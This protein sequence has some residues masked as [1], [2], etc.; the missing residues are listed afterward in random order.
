MSVE[1]APRLNRRL[2]RRRNLTDP[3][4]DGSVGTPPDTNPF[5]EI[6]RLQATAGNRAVSRMLDGSDQ[7]SA[8]QFVPV[9]RLM[10][11]RQFLAASGG[12]LK[13]K[14]VIS[15]D[16]A[17]S[18]Y[19]K[20]DDQDFNARKQAAAALV[21]ACATYLST[22]YRSKARK[23]GVRSLLA[24]A[25]A[26][27]DLY[28]RLAATEGL[29][30]SARMSAL[31][32]LSDV[33]AGY[34]MRLGDET[35]ATLAIQGSLKTLIQKHDQADPSVLAKV[36]ERE[37][38]HLQDIA[39]DRK[40]PPVVRQIVAEN[41][42][43]IDKIHLRASEAPGGASPGARLPK[44]GEDT[45]G[46]AYVVNHALYQAGGSAE[47][48]GSLLHELTHVASGEEIGHAPLFVVFQ[49]GKQ[50]TPEGRRELKQLAFARKANVDKM[51]AL[52]EGSSS[53]QPGQRK[54]LAGKLS[55]AANPMLGEYV[56][57]F[58]QQLG[59]DASAEYKSMK[60]LAED[61]EIIGISST[62]IEYDSVINQIVLWYH[63]WGVPL[64]E[65]SYALAR[66][67]AVEA[68]AYRA[69]QGGA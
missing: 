9:Q 21:D 43:H 14:K 36:M 49:K 44:Q 34:F 25:A 69:T 60:L 45:G 62:L 52:V 6:T 22:S 24:Q 46:K 30:Y 59:G 4:G 23:E 40:A 29:D 5:S 41:L 8:T 48:G 67:L 10:S 63:E 17:L 11:P 26:E 33:A 68:R 47:R 66:D 2:L 53:L 31:L 1:R 61:P 19:H 12:D 27:A 65:P 51:K 39:A 57:R 15:V 35:N 28:S 64:D 42:V 13:R 56:A 20:A 38:G 58:Q 54:L 32:D 55:Y 50:N 16:D 37:V 18:E 3:A 7:Q